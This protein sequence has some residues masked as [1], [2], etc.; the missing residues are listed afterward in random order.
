MPSYIAGHVTVMRFSSENSIKYI[1]NIPMLTFFVVDD[2][3][4]VLLNYVL[5]IKIITDMFQ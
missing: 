5:N 4:F 1:K 2:D 3:N